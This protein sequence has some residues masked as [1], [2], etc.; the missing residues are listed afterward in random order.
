MFLAVPFPIIRIACPP[1]SRA[2]AGDLPVF[3]IDGNLSPVVFSPAF[4]LTH[5]LAADRLT[6]LKLR[7]WKGL[8][9]V[10]AAAVTHNSRCLTLPGWRDG[11]QR[12][13]GKPADLFL[14]EIGARIDWE[15]LQ[16]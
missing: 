6:G 5:C 1:F 8:L 9:T 16:I 11:E 7:R 10:T 3:R 12:R 14:T 15:A 13:T 4:T 2:I